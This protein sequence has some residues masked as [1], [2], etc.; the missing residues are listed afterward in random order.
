MKKIA[1]THNLRT[2]PCVPLSIGDYFRWRILVDFCLSMFK[3][4]LYKYVQIYKILKHATDW[5]VCFLYIFSAWVCLKCLAYND[6]STIVGSTV[7]D[8][9][10]TF[11][12]ENDRQRTLTYILV[13][14]T[15]ELQTKTFL[16]GTTS[17]SIFVSIV[18]QETLTTLN[19]GML[20][21][22]IFTLTMCIY[23]Q[24]P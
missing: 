11:C 10:S 4:V 7:F 8:Y 19:I 9:W 22:S 6:L 1:E 17:A 3:H 20:L 13:S 21:V 24:V 14:V 5:A 15:E 16:V 18:P 23:P 12:A 2:T